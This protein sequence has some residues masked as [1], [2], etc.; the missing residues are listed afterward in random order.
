MTTNAKTAYLDIYIG[1][2]EEYDKE[3]ERYERTK[4][5]L[6]KNAVTFGFPEEPERLSMEQQEIL[7]EV[8]VLLRSISLTTLSWR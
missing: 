1:Y 8:D 6:K 2:R 3:E 4:E 7:K 5:V